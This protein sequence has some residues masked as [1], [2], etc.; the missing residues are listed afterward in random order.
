MSKKTSSTAARK[1]TKANG[2]KAG[3]RTHTVAVEPDARKLPRA[4]DVKFVEDKPRAQP[5]NERVI[6]GVIDAFT[7]RVCATVNRKEVQKFYG[8]RLDA[9]QVLRDRELAGDALG[10]AARFTYG[11]DRATQIAAPAL[12]RLL[13]AASLI[14]RDVD[15]LV[16][17][18]PD[19][20]DE[21][22]DLTDWW[23]GAFPGGGPK[24]K[25]NGTTT[26]ADPKSPGATATS[27]T[28]SKPTTGDEAS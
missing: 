23:N 2:N 7:G 12:V 22:T 21:L 24:Q 11:A 19:F 3:S 26:P 18:Y 9:S 20:K 13:N 14:V 8:D 6:H 15:V 10:V 17:K 25:S 27:A 4:G 28:S 16:A 1:T 5:T